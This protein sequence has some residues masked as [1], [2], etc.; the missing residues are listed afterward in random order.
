MTSIR[1]TLSD[2]ERAA[3]IA[4]PYYSVGIVKLMVLS[5]CTF[6]LY[7]IWWCYQQW[8]REQIRLR[9]D[10]SPL[11]RAFF[12][13]IWVF[14][15]L[16]RVSKEASRHRVAAT[17][18]PNSLAVSVIVLTLLSRLPDPYWLLGLLGFLPFIPVQRTINVL[19]A[20][21]A[22]G[23]DANRRL[24]G[25]SLAVAVIGGLF[26]VLVLWGVLFIPETS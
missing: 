22:P 8:T 20:Q 13:L 23:S 4:A 18:S 14:S 21:T 17:W 1:K 9:E 6:G 19:N 12:T 2:E 10:L 11:W 26:L 25:G 24:S 5:L 7:V 16:E 3:Y 15:L